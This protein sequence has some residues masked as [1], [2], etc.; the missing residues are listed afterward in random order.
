MSV[1]PERTERFTIELC[2]IRAMGY[3]GVLPEEQER[4]QP[5]EVDLRVEVEAP[6]ALD[7]DD[8]TDTV[9][10][11]ALVEM[12]ERVLAGERFSLLERAAARMADVILEDL[13][14]RAVS[15]VVR[16]L[17]PPLAVDVRTVGVRLERSR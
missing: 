8:I 3:C 1:D 5:L 11:A 6:A 7:S 9:D 2:G 16:K 13:R 10:Y 4:R 17:R 15:V 12:V 14:V